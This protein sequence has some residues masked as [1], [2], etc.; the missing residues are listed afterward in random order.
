MPSCCTKDRSRFVGEN[1][2]F[3]LPIMMA[4]FGVA[5]LIVWG[6]GA[7][8]AG[9]WSGAFFSVATGF[10]GPVAFDFL[11][12]DLWGIVADTAFATGFLLF[13]QALLTH[14]PARLPPMPSIACARPRRWFA[15]SSTARRM[16][17]W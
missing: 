10:S 9:W 13:S 8:E 6:W 15:A 16:T 7:R 12:T 4:S 2:A 14:W 5:F 17:T 11:P 3:F 1:F